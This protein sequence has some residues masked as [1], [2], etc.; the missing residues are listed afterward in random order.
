MDFATDFR[1]RYGNTAAIRDYCSYPTIISVPLF[2]PLVAY[3]L[4][5][6]S[7]SIFGFPDPSTLRIGGGILLLLLLLRRSSTPSLV[8]ATALIWGGLAA[9]MALSP[10]PYHTSLIH[11]IE[12]SQVILEGHVIRVE[13]QPGR[14]RM[15]MEVN[16]IQRNGL[17][18]DARGMRV[19]LHIANGT[20][21]VYAGDHVYLRTQLRQPRVFGTPGEF[22]YSRYLAQQDIVAS[23][24][25]ADGSTIARLTSKHSESITDRI[26]RWR[27]RTGED[28]A[29]M[30]SRDSSAY[31]LSLALGE[32][33]RLSP[34]Q[35]ETL[36]FTGL[37]HLFSISGLHL[38]MIAAFAYAIISGIYRRSTALLIWQPVQ[39][40]APFL[41]LP[42]VI[43]YLILSGGALP[44]IR[45]SFM[46][47]VAAVLAL[48][49]YRTRPGAVL[50][51]AAALILIADPLALLSASFHLSF[52]G[53]G[54]LL[55]VLP[56]WHRR[57]H[58]GWRKTLLLLF[59]TSYTACLATTPFALWHFHTLAPAAVFN[60]IFAVPLVSFIVLPL[61][62]GGTALFSISPSFGLPLLEWSATL[63]TI[64]L[65]CAQ[66]LASGFLSGRY[67]YLPLWNFAALSLICAALILWAANLRR[68]G[69]VSMGLAFALLICG[70]FPLQN[71][72]R[73]YLTALSIGQADAF[74]VQ[75]PD[76]SN[77]LVDGGGLYSDSFDTGSQLIAPA[78]QNL[79]VTHLDGVILTHDHPDHSKGLQHILHYFPT[80]AFLCGA[81]QQNLSSGLQAAL[82]HPEAPE[83]V[84]LPEG[85]IRLDDYIYLH[86][87]KQ[88]N[89]QVN[90]RSIAVFGGYGSQGFLLTGDLETRGMEQLLEMEN[91]TPVTLFKLPHHGSRNSMPHRWLETWSITHT[92]ASCGYNNHFGFPHPEICTMLKEANIPLWRTDLH[93]TIR[94]STNGKDWKAHSW[95]NPLTNP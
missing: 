50:L 29:A 4:G 48:I 31:V 94:F 17:E 80:T 18:T 8:T 95:K 82:R 30:L 71:S 72:D 19:R 51:L 87:P 59:L 6:A 24:M 38:G 81:E 14:W 12:N 68:S 88:N 27:Q 7:V 93:G 85:T 43:L 23:G 83:T 65:E 1:R 56:V 58:P 20:P 62:L 35:R 36:A 9:W 91:P 84:T 45:A 73:L 67:V 86:I 32:K 33:S 25:V 70:A 3:M 22:N 74:L 15:D 69:L 53:V 39:K 42:F 60:N 64:V 46:L 5:V 41:C 28:I 26:R 49:N 16:S 57:F 13:A 55:L 47:G 40:T 11:K 37:S 54:S 76:N 90:E 77:Y 21:T 75:T 63:I 2:F 78:L 52:A 66:T 10:D 61:S 89:P 92:V 34:V 44:T 79:G